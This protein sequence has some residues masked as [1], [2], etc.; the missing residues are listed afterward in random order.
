[1]LS[2][3]NHWRRGKVFGSL[4][5]VCLVAAAVLS[6]QAADKY[7]VGG[8]SGNWSDA[9]WADTAGGEG[10]AWVDGSNAIFDNDSAVSV[11]CD[12]AA[13]IGTLS[14]SGSG[15][16]TLGGTVTQT[17]TKVTS[18]Q[19]VRHVINCPVKFT[20][21]LQ[22]DFESAPV[23]FAGGAT[24]TT[25]AARDNEASRTLVGEFHLTENWNNTE[26]LSYTYLVTADSRFYGKSLWG[27]QTLVVFRVDE[28][29]YAEFSGDVY[30]GNGCGRISVLGEMVVNGR[31]IVQNSAVGH[32]GFDGD[33][34]RHGIIRAKGVWKGDDSHN[35][36]KDV[37]VKIP[38]L[39]VG[40]DGLGAK[41]QDYGIH[42]DGGNQT[43]YATD[44]FEIFSPVRE[45]D[46][47]DWGLT[48]DKATTFNTQGR[49][50][51][52]T[53]GARGGG[54]ITKDGDG[55]LI[56]NPHGASLS[57][58]VAVN[59][60]ALR[61][62]KDGAIGTGAITV[63]DG[64]R[65]EVASGVT[66]SNVLDGD[67]TL[68]LEDGTTV[69]VGT[70]PWHAGTVEV[71]SGATVTVTNTTGAAAAIAFLSGVSAAD[72]PRFTITGNTL[73]VV[74][75]VLVA[76]GN[77]TGAYVWNGADGADWSVPGN[78]LVEGVVPT[79]APASTDTILFQN[80]AP[81]TVGGTDPLTVT[82]IVTL[83][84]DE[85]TFNCPVQ[86][87]G[88][89]LV[90]NAATAPVF[91][92]GATAT[93][94][95]ASLTNEN[96][97]SHALRGVI[98]FTENWTIPNQPA[99]NP[100][101]V[102]AGARVSGKT[103]TAS[104][105]QN[106]NYHLRIDEGAVA[107]FE[108]VAV[109]GK[110]VFHLN[111][112]DLV[113]TGDVTLGGEDKR[114]FGYYNAPNNG[115]VE[116]H[117]IYKSVTGAGRVYHYITNM[118]VGAGG[119]GMYRK[120]YNI[121]FCR[122]SKLTAKDNL[123]IHQ[124]IAEDGPK[125]GDW[126]LNLDGKTFTID[127]AGHTVTFD[128]WVSA[129]AAK[130]V[131]E[132]EGEM[133]MQS[134]Q[135][136]H[137]GGTELNGGLTTVK[138][139]GALGYGTAT[140]N[141]GATL[142]FADSVLNFAYPI[143]VN[144]G[145]TLANA[146]TVADTSTLT[147]NA[148][149]TLKPVQNTFFDLSAGTL[150]L[151]AEGTVTVDMTEFTFVNGVPNPVLCGVADGNEGKFTALVPEG[152]VGS[153]S[154]SNGFLYYTVTSGGSAAADLFWS[155]QGDDTWSTAVT[156]WTNAAGEQVTFTPYANVTVADA[157]TIS[158]PADV[159]ANDVKIA[160][161]GDVALNGAG[162]LGGP[163]SII[164]TGEGTFTFNATGG[165]DAQP[166]IVSNGVFKVGDDLVNH[167]LGA[168]ADSSPIIVEDGGTLD[169]NY[170][171]STS[172]SDASRSSVTRDKL[173]RIAGDG[174]N[175]QGAIVN[176]SYESLA[177]LSDL[178][179]DADASVGGS[180]RFDVRGSQLNY[181]RNSA[182][183]NG[184]GKT[185]TVKTTSPG[186]FGIVNATVNL[187]S[188]VVTNGGVL[189]MEGA[190]YHLDRGIRLVDGGTVDFYQG[191]YPADV[192]I[193]A[194]SGANT[195]KNSSGTVTF[196]GPITVSPGATLTH[197]GGTINYNGGITGAFSQTGGTIGFA[198]PINNGPID[199]AGGTMYLN[200]GV[201]ESGFTLNG[202]TGAGT[203]Y[204]RQG[205]TFSGANIT[206]QS[207]CVA[208]FANSTVDVTFN[209]S[210]FNLYNL[211]LGWGS[212]NGASAP[213]GYLSIGPG[214][215]LTANKIC[216]GD[217][218][219]STSNNIKSIMSVDGGNVHLTGTDF[220]IAHDGPHSVFVMNSGTATVDQATIRLRNH[221]EPLGGY[222]NS[223]FI[224]NG[225]TVNYGGAG[226]TA[227]WEDNSDEGQIILKGGAFN[228][229]ANWSIPHFIPMYFKSGDANGWTLNQ[230]DGTT[231]TWNTA[232]LGDG[233]V[234]LN[235]A[236]T[237]AGNKEVQ[238]AVGG[239][240]TVGDGFT[241]GLQGAASLLGGLD[242]GEG[243]SV[244]VDI[245]TNRSA[246][247][248][249]RDFGDN[250]GKSGCI[251]NR[252]NRAIGGT[253]RG[254]I[255]HD[256]TFF[257]TSYAQGSRPFGNM[258]Y[259]STYAVGDFYVEDDSAGEW[260]FTAICDDW[261]MFWVDG[262]LVVAPAQGKQG[263]GTKNLAAGWHSF[264]H[265]I[266]DHG[267]S[268][269][270]AQSIGYKDGSGTMSSYANFSTKNLK[271]RPAADKGDPN[272]A[273]TV[274]WSHYK[275]DSTTVTAST[276]KNDFAWDFRC[277][278]N[279]LQNLQVY[280]KTDETW[281]NGYTVNRY[282][283]WFFVDDDKADKEW[284]FRSKYDD[285]CALWIDGV[286]SGLDG[287][288]NSTL[289]YAVTLA[290]GW[291]KFRIQTADFTGNAGPWKGN[292]NFVSYQ[293]AGGAQTLFS[294]QTLALSVCPDGYI[295]GDVKLASGATLSNTATGAALVY[296]DVIATGT[297]A[298]ISGGFKFEGGKLAFQNVA[299][300]T[301]DLSTVLA[302]TNPADDYLADVGAITVD[303]TAK[304]KRGKVV[305]CPAGGLTS[306]TA[307]SKVTV[308]VNG[309][310]C[311][312]SVGVEDGN[313]V[314]RFPVGSMLFVR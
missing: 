183:I 17:V 232:L 307:A 116:A 57:G 101:V 115:T 56:M 192:A 304:S 137:T 268:Y 94:P 210:T 177:T 102:A 10:G 203:V 167:A 67:G 21:T 179:L 47:T 238:G 143:V 170:N 226:F 62:A 249:A 298:T 121:Q 14:F 233:D 89:Y 66:M 184:P 34:S 206:A 266:I 147:L 152:I 9:S 257:F 13:T 129:T 291:H 122:D 148:G 191:T 83:S 185:L 228:A 150:N 278:T 157:A 159:S 258:N 293:L 296:G 36:N 280:T 37:Y 180:K 260:S 84:Y 80:T 27:N 53:G 28:G 218:G 133:I 69:S 308:T 136:Q 20:S 88:T 78:W 221:N 93:Y 256:M 204:F 141:D 195:I 45:A 31:W 188:I 25:P 313:V 109:A 49:T 77:T 162:K 288:E 301:R 169:V 297:N 222:N 309:E 197:T 272:N 175:G 75:G 246:V 261:A 61:L 7:W 294:E 290:K 18:S 209:N 41:K 8:A 142:A 248:T 154:V 265:I 263:T 303:L 87:A 254:T 243:A 11:T 285:R 26:N 132:G 43:V 146:A 282:D 190:T 166:I 182:S 181:A 230:A 44:D 286:D 199:F 22:L 85:V 5:S 118:V 81:V 149:A 107:T 153:F 140:V 284:T 235:G 267:G 120:D 68:R 279:N 172:N 96:I 54:S 302:F 106:V 38:N 111:G 134:R 242:I 259:S 72:L 12:S 231:A 236:A 161:D 202:A 156:A 40:S 73:A 194:E 131:K 124:P 164:K 19:D 196:N 52:W 237:L 311:R 144:D 253:T 50:I 48:I 95:D 104:S 277:I 224:Q 4:L 225:G 71:A 229:S 241:A 58:A 205:G 186:A 6:A 176:N 255:T 64:A 2:V 207:F 63:A 213:S 127:T 55:T 275:G 128:S 92:G 100:F 198:G 173:V 281:L 155:P 30:T 117:G 90:Q 178:V 110:L 214:T 35:M 264:R 245:A 145:G 314:L 112:G 216:I 158:L 103:V 269:G 79:T 33:E 39:Y 168:T 59:G 65:L 276:F 99:G 108:T 270:N 82:R 234:T 283:G 262:E 310:P 299:P 16:V 189:R 219:T 105:Y 305:V 247:F 201:P 250:P 151:P 70:T 60:G 306:E 138:L 74:D 215:T 187:D 130:I 125:D 15:L 126:G 273:N 223:E 160:A 51:T 212:G 91:A 208:D 220:F 295:Q 240:W 32:V 23:N 193:T 139:A 119:F 292:G 211:Y 97:P 287:N 123:T 113:A 163:G 217:D 300:N 114:D 24:A 274:R 271:M 135:K 200:S 252:F 171:V 42:F 29:G 1:M 244:T 76:T 86:F 46:K 165:L 3:G 312:H 174:F 289:T 98:T 227:N 251:T 239:K